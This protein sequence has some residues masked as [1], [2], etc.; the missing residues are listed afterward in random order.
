MSA[1]ET[2]APARWSL[3]V[4]LGG[5]NLL[6]A[7]RTCVAGVLALAIAFWMEMQDPQWAILTVFLLA[8]PTAGGAMA[9]SVYRAAGTI[10]G[11]CAGLVILAFWAEAP[12]PLVGSVALW[13]G[14]CYYFSARL[15]NFVAY[16]FMLAA[17][18]ALLVALEGAAAPMQAWLIAADRTA[19]ILIGIGCATAA[20]VLVM[21]RYAGVMLREGM[22]RLFGSLNHYGAVALTP[23]TAP[24]TFAALRRAMVEAIVKFDALRSYAVFE[25]P[26]LR[27]DDVQLRHMVREF[28]RVLAV[29]RGLYIRIEDYRGEETA[30]MVA[31]MKPVM[32]DTGALLERLSRTPH[33]IDD[34]RAVR[35]Q[36]LGARA[37]IGRAAAALEAMAGRAP[38]EPLAGG[39]LI[40][41][42]TADLLHGLSLVMVSEAATLRARRPNAVRRPPPPVPGP[43]RLE[44]ALIG[45]RAALAVVIGCSL[46][47]MTEAR[48]GA[49]ML[50]GIGMMLFFFVNQDRPGRVGAS[51]I[52]WCVAA[53]VTAFVVMGLIL[54]RLEGF[55]EL[56]VL[57]ILLLMPGALMAGTPR[58]SLPGVVLAAFI[59]AQLGS[60]NQFGSTDVGYLN[61]NLA[62]VV[63]MALC[64]CVVTLIPATSQGTRPHFRRL[65]LGTL[66]PLAARGERHERRILGEI[67]DRLAELM[68]RLALD[69]PEEEDF[70]RG[71]LG[72]ASTSL[73]LGRLWRLRR[74]ADTAPA[75]RAILDPMLARFADAME[76]LA[77]RTGGPAQ[78]AQAEA[79]VQDALTAL[80]AL[81]LEPGSPEA[82]RALRAGASLR[83]IADRFEIDRA[84]YLARVTGGE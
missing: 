20:T 38:F 34:P 77:P 17:Y 61:G 76:A 33:L 8:Q 72:A 70:L 53:L 13:V 81:P 2:P 4:D 51:V 41:R 47:A 1:V 74:D 79:A 31:V 57:L 3:P 73:E 37:D 64:L 26:E 84:F 21:P 45:L 58:V 62:F 5:Y 16:S 71:S 29:A 60:N 35:A 43:V 7:L 56:A 69:R 10:V 67:V 23:G 49:T 22:A 50:T 25:A 24:A 52:L 54:P 15:T 18:T 83:F 14:G 55:G 27:A 78:L 40:L 65:V 82:A 44:A 59:G 42:R 66:L 9:K 63:G 36:L 39:L 30:E 11:A 75:L 80:A 19:A 48:Y 12:V 28:L 46:W 6:F 68:P 32:L